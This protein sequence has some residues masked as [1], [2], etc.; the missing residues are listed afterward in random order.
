VHRAL[1]VIPSVYTLVDDVQQFVSGAPARIRRLARKWRPA[2]S[3]LQPTRGTL[4]Q[5]AAASTAQ[6]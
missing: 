2:A 1:L 4:R 5:P 6:D 3:A